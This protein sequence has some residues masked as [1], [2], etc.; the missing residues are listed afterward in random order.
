LVHVVPAIGF[1][2]VSNR[3]LVVPPPALKPILLESLH[4]DEFIWKWILARLPEPLTP[5]APG[6]LLMI[7]TTPC[8]AGGMKPQFWMLTA[9]MVSSP[10]LTSSTVPLVTKGLTTEMTLGSYIMSYCAESRS[11]T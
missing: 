10:G 1:D 3:S 5:E 8:V 11:S 7:L 6:M 4:V 2:K 9:Q